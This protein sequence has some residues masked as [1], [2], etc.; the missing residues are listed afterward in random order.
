MSDGEEATNHLLDVNLH[1]S[2]GSVQAT[3]GGLQSESEHLHVTIGATVPT[4]FEQTAADEVREK[5]GSA[6]RISKDRGKIYFDISVESLAQVHSL[7]SVD[8][9]FVVVQEFK[10][11]QFKSTK[12]EVLKDFEDLA[13][14]LS[15]SDPLKVWEMNSSFK[16]KKTK[17]KKTNQNSNKGKTDNGQGD[18]KR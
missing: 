14:K 1:E 5:L 15:W 7:R 18:K 9:L 3:E 12:E 16:K 11:Y 2:Q 8:N 6:C 10:D 17:R 4:G 13:G